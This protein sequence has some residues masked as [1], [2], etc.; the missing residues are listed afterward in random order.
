MGCNLIA[1]SP[2]RTHFS[3]RIPDLPVIRE[4]RGAVISLVEENKG[5]KGGL[6]QFGTVTR[7]YIF[8]WHN[9]ALRIP[10]VLPEAIITYCSLISISMHRNFDKRFSA[11]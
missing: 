7:G 3:P 9:E 1:S 8:L 10:P 4:D 11:R 2:S 6:I 5:A